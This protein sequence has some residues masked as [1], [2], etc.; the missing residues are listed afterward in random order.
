[1]SRIRF[2]LTEETITNNF[3]ETL[4]RI[5]ATEDIPARFVSAGD[6]GGWVSSTHTESGKPRI[7]KNAWV[8]GGAEVFGQARVTGHARVSDRAQIYGTARVKGR[9]RVQDDAQ[10]KDSATVKGS[11]LIQGQARIGDNATVKGSAQVLGVVEGNAKV[12]GRAVISSGTIN[13]HAVVADAATVSRSYVTGS[14][15]VSGNA[16][17][18]ADSL[19]SEDAVIAGQAKIRFS[20]VSGAAHITAPVP[21]HAT[22]T[23]NAEITRLWHCFS[24][25]P[26]G[27]TD[28]LATVY[29]CVGDEI[30][31]ECDTEVTEEYQP[32]IDV[33]TEQIRRQAEPVADLCFELTEE[34]K[35]LA[36]GTTVFRIRATKD[37]EELGVTVG[38]LGGW[39]SSLFTDNG[40][41]RLDNAWVAD[42]AVL[43]DNALLA[44]QAIVEHYAVVKDNAQVTGASVI[45]GR[46]TLAGETTVAAICHIGG[47]GE[48]RGRSC[49]HPVVHVNIS[50]TI[51]DADFYDS[52]D[53]VSFGP[54]D[55]GRLITVAK[56]RDRGSLITVTEVETGKHHSMTGAKFLKSIEPDVGDLRAEITRI[57][58]EWELAR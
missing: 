3:G 36:D 4:Y 20:T 34:T 38:D 27:H 57:L 58:R 19:I 13:G 39:V 5:R 41:P 18:G 26:I 50:G 42:E 9:A 7:G 37:Q 15:E 53:F 24:F 29:R 23:G 10:V 56:L 30:A 22:V 11:C 52:S 1:M 8:E 14:A 12:S 44:D 33:A 6:L 40:Q 55:D 2:E 28:N 31:V 51:S 54:L 45:S 46:V 25:G 43:R 17:V 47:D 32:V 35:E 49:V 48:L 21:S 16:V